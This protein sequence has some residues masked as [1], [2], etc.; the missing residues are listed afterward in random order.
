MK[1][2]VVCIVSLKMWPGGWV[3]N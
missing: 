1:L 3:Q 2:G